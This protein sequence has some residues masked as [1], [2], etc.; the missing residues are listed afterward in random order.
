MHPTDIIRAFIA[1]RK[2]SFTLGILAIGAAQFIQVHIPRILGDFINRLKTGGVTEAVI[3][4]FAAQLAA[5][6]AGYVLAFGFGQTR[7]GELG[8]M[9]EFDLRQSLFVHWETLSSRYFQRHSVGD[10]L[11]HSLNDVRAVRQAM[12]MGLNQIS[13]AVFLFAATLFMAISTINLSLTI[14]SLIPILFIPVVVVM[15]GPRVRRRSRRVQEALSTM[16]EMAEESFQAIRLIKGASNEPVEVARFTRLVDDIFHRQMRLVELN[17]LFQALLPLLSGISFTIGLVY[18]GWLVVHG[19]ISL[20]SFVAFTVYLSML[21]HP[22]LQFGVVINT[23]QNASASLVR[24]GTLLA[25]QPDI[26]DPEE[27]VERAEWNG[28]VDVSN[29]TFSYPENQ[30]VVLDHV[31]FSVPAGTTLGIVGRTGAGKTTLL[32]MIL[33][34][35]DPPGGTVYIDGVDIR[36]LRLSTLRGLI[37]YVP[38]DGFLFSTTIGRNIAFSQPQVE[39][40]AVQRAA[41]QSRIWDTIRAMPE[42]IETQI[43]ERGI[44]LSGGQRQRTAIARALI[45]SQ[46]KILILDD[47]LSAVDTRTETEILSMLRKVRGK[48]TVLIAAHRLSALRDADRI[49]VLDHGSM[50]E[51]GTHLELMGKNGLY[52]H[53]F[54]IQAG[55]ES[56]HG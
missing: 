9:L 55:E 1:K 33:R 6:A 25:V 39:A 30:T 51:S 48:K 13:Q 23:F 38:Q 49:L 47:S 18:G 53:L 10:L 35:V 12:S 28:S 34:D 3:L 24:I 54:R 4:G 41:D 32:N 7:V 31:T 43:G 36:A 22:L 29:L 19:Q 27:P 14:I 44:M 37:A 42:G 50:V 45:K 20:G 52:A 21:V 15:V 5:V 46:A 16:S 11:N 26:T 2:W 40:D 17:T 8:R 56:A